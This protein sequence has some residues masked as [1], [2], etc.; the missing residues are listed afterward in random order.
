LYCW[1]TVNDVRLSQSSGRR[2]HSLPPVIP[3]HTI[4]AATVVRQWKGGHH[5][6]SE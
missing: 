3:P 5:L 6:N 1:C 4:A 2:N